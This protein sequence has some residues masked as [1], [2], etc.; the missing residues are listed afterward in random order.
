MTSVRLVTSEGDDVFS[1][2]P[3]DV[4]DHM[5]SL[6]SVKNAAAMSLVSKSWRHRWETCPNLD[7]DLQFVYPEEETGA[8]P[9]SQQKQQGYANWVNRVLASHRGESVK[10]FRIRSTLAKECNAYADIDQWILHALRKRAQTL[11][12]VDMPRYESG[13]LLGKYTLPLWFSLKDAPF[14]EHLTLRSICLG[15]F[16]LSCINHLT[17]LTL[18]NVVISDT[19]AH[20]MLR[21]CIHLR[22]LS[23]LGCTSISITKLVVPRHLQ[24]QHLSLF[25]GLK[26]LREVEME[27]GESLESFECPSNIIQ[28]F[29]SEKLRNLR[30]LTLLDSS[31]LDTFNY[32]V[33]RLALDLPNLNK[34]HLSAVG[35]V[36]CPEN[37]VSRS[38]WTTF[39]QLRFLSLSCFRMSEE[40]LIKYV[41]LFLRMSP[42]L[43]TL[44]LR[45]WDFTSEHHE[46]QLTKRRFESEARND[47]N[48]KVV[49]IYGFEH[50]Q[51]A[52][53]LV[54]YI[55]ESCVNLETLQIDRRKQLYMGEGEWR[56]D[57]NQKCES[58][59]D[60][61]SEWFRTHVSSNA[62][63]VV[64]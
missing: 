49:R 8:G 3:E 18:N 10:L 4:V 39:G 40:Q 55:L 16:E 57:A 9:M 20:D 59:P 60:G 46:Q 42:I 11:I 21:N 5:A 28:G 23:L 53:D 64:L 25:S 32:V 38:N 30:K 43:H 1:S 26:Y 35:G 58:S 44:E 37:D 17:S 12:I 48:L 47:C 36:Y 34:F 15:P 24:L 27:G 45:Q 56:T 7:F 13:H 52:L 50:C 29:S 14:L 61:I 54:A 22:R 2:L 33:T 19:W 31:R 63:L 62:Q 41:G 6:L 51:T